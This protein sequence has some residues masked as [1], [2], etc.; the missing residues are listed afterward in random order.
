MTH[1]KDL[2]LQFRALLLRK[3]AKAVT[4]DRKPIDHADV[5][6]P[7][8]SWRPAAADDVRQGQ[9]TLR[10]QKQ[11]RLSQDQNPRD[12]TTRGSQDRDHRGSGME[13]SVARAT[14]PVDQALP[15]GRTS[16]TNPNPVG[17]PNTTENLGPE[18]LKTAKGAK[19]R[20]KSKDKEKVHMYTISMRPSDHAQIFEWA[21]ERGMTFSALLRIAAFEY[22][23]LKSESRSP[24]Q[25]MRLE[26]WDKKKREG[27]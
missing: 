24:V 1:T 12:G 27:R 18:I 4:A 2:Q 20:L 26:N 21:E 16:R 15:I 9:A 11:D 6:R 8:D 14:G 10:K 13:K 5:T 19:A 3:R 7:P 25:E 23:G 22:T 17:S